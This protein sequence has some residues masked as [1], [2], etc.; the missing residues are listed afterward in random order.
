MNAKTQIIVLL[1]SYL[2]GFFFFYLYKLN[3]KIIKKTNK[4]YRSIITILFMYNIVLL[5]IIIIY[6]AN[7]G[8]FHIYFLLML[9]LGFFTSIKFTKK[10]SKNV[11]LHNF[12]EKIKKK[13]YT[14]KK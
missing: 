7:N 5:Y 4:L 13:C 11:N 6:K 10:I 14:I 9:I 3:N 2:Y 8:N 12:L 1:I